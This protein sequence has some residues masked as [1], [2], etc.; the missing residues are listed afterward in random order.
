MQVPHSKLL[1]PPALRQRFE[2]KAEAEDG[3]EDDVD[4]ATMQGKS[5]IALMSQHACAG[6]WEWLSVDLLGETLRRCSV[7]CCFRSLRQH[8]PG[9]EWRAVLAPCLRRQLVLVR[10]PPRGLQSEQQ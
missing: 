4:T 3:E 7:L 5:P 6:G 10:W 2:E 9:G 1:A 8:V